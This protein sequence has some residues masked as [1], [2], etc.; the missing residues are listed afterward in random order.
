MSDGVSVLARA[1]DGKTLSRRDVPRGGFPRRQVGAWVAVALLGL[2]LLVGRTLL[3]AS[4]ALR[5]AHA[6]QNAGRSVEAIRG[7]AEA[8]RLHVPGSPYSVEGQEALLAMAV[9]ARETG[10]LALELRARQALAAALV[11]TGRA[12]PPRSPSFAAPKGEQPTRQSAE[13]PREPTGTGSETSLRLLLASIAAATSAAF[14]FS[15][16]VE[17]GRRL[18]LPWALA[19]SGAFAA[20]LWLALSA[21]ATG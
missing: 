1:P 4:A 3:E 15:R 16:G 19:T 13:T 20:A 17:R 12:P 11:A 7:Y 6:A 5:E 8:V 18:V 21:L 14:F 9:A 10:N 2:S